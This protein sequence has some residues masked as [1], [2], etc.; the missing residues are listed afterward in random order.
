MKAFF[1]RANPLVAWRDLR[2]FVAQPQPYRWR[3]LALSAAATYSIFAVMFAQEAKGPPPPPEIIYIETWR[4]DRSDA[5]IVAGNIA[6]TAERKEREAQ[7]AASRERVRE[8]YKTLGRMSGMD[9]EKIEREARAQQA[10]EAA[11]KTEAEAA[12]RPRVQQVN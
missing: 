2:E 6:A 3:V 4:A 5:E 1:R 7:L 8:M 9:V 10:A 11:A 12:L